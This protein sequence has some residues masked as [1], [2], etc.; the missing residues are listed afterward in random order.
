VSRETALST[1]DGQR[2]CHGA[3][4]RWLHDGVRARV[5]AVLF[6][7]SAP[8]LLVASSELSLGAGPGLAWWHIA[9]PILALLAAMAGA[10]AFA[11]IVLVAPIRELT[12]AVQAWRPGAAFAPAIPARLPDELRQLAAAFA[13]AAQIHA[14]RERQL[15]LA[16]QQQAL[17][18]REIHHRVKNNLQI[19]AS[20]LNLQAS[21]IR[22]P[23]ARRE[24]A[25]ARDRVRALATLHRHLYAQDDL[26]TINMRSFLTELCDQLLQAMAET[27]SG[28]IDLQIEA[29]ELQL[30][31]DQAV[32]MAL[33]VTEAVSNALR[34]AF[35]AGRDG[36][37]RV[38]LTVA[39]EQAR[40]VVEDNGVG[41]PAGT[42]DG[43]ADPHE[44]IGLHLIRGFARQLGGQ[45]TIGQESGTRYDLA[46][47]LRRDQAAAAASYAMM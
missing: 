26:H 12:Q 2:R 25:A 23:E 38:S 7:A 34:Y 16:S 41:L 14:E 30:S 47:E 3:L 15:S 8:L 39:G 24:F 37:V 44:G 17:L 27:I 6:L 45:L 40:L 33:I 43:Q 9:L 42:A 20:L 1:P 5:V 31:S 13:E 46:L 35:P 18:M 11:T 22:L 32:P 29:P 10:A 36:H 19:V 21:R 4:R 28:H